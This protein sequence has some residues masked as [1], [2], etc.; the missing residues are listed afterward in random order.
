MGQPTLNTVVTI[1]MRSVRFPLLYTIVMWELLFCRH[2]CVCMHACVYVNNVCACAWRWVS[3]GLDGECV[4][5]SVCVCVCVC[6]CACGWVS[7]GL[8][9]EWV[10]VCV[11]VGV[12]VLV[13]V[14]ESVQV[15]VVSVSASV[16]VCACACGW[17]SSGLSG[18]ELSSKI[19]PTLSVVNDKLCLLALS[20][21]PH[22]PSRCSCGVCLD[23]FPP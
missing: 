18:C 21:P 20:P 1:N 5:V 22:L 6:A 3:S 7:S 19:M 4:W 10:C 17:V 9:G 15:S 14:G 11:H 2:V 23:A 12:C 13:H 16:C 8:S